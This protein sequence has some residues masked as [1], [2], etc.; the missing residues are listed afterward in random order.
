MITLVIILC[1]LWFVFYGL[2][3]AYNFWLFYAFFSLLNNP[4]HKNH[5][6]KRRHSVVVFMH[7]Q[8]LSVIPAMLFILKGKEQLSCS[9]LV[10]NS[11]VSY[12][13][14]SFKHLLT[15]GKTHWEENCCFGW[16]L[17]K[18]SLTLLFVP[19]TEWVCSSQLSLTTAAGYVLV[20]RAT[21][22]AFLHLSSENR[23]YCS[24]CHWTKAVCPAMSVKWLGL[25][26]G[27]TAISCPCLGNRNFH[28][29]AL[30]ASHLFPE[31]SRNSKASFVGT[32]HFTNEEPTVSWLNYPVFHGRGSWWFWM[33]TA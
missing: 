21:S 1:K 32:P 33:S 10:S 16:L 15:G 24:A 18:T 31:K 20:E 22:A 2:P 27:P 26:S 13:S 28:L 7:Q 4:S 19:G 29:R 30:L 23:G 14:C 12:S 6:G 25:R 9:T 11:A 3:V 5:R 17:P 8:T